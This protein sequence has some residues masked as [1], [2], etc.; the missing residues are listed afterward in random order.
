MQHVDGPRPICSS[1]FTFRSSHAETWTFHHSV[2][3]IL[4]S[5]LNLSKSEIDNWKLRQIQ[6]FPCEIEFEGFAISGHRCLLA[7][8][9]FQSRNKFLRIQK[10]WIFNQAQI[11]VRSKHFRLIWNSISALQASTVLY[12]FLEISNLAKNHFEFLLHLLSL[13]HLKWVST[14]TDQ[15]FSSSPV[16]ETKMFP[17]TFLFLFPSG[18]TLCLRWWGHKRAF[19]AVTFAP[20]GPLLALWPVATAGE[21]KRQ[22]RISLKQTWEPGWGSGAA[23]STPPAWPSPSRWRR[24]GRWWWGRPSCPSPPTPA[25]AAS[26]AAP[27]GRA[28][29]ALRSCE[30]CLQPR[31]ECLTWNQSVSTIKSSASMWSG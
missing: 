11:S 28:L 22:S 21:N 12:L 3:S 10:H 1:Q 6:A 24:L 7:S 30:G 14:D 4:L 31:G 20:G 16:S 25:P 23:W 2:T 15:Y 18:E 19:K 13:Y 17:S 26:R 27:S 29:E 9:S 8:S 5:N